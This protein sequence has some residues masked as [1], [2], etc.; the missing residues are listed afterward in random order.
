MKKRSSYYNRTSHPQTKNNDNNKKHF[1]QNLCNSHPKNKNLSPSLS[2]LHL[3]RQ[4]NKFSKKP[5]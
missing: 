3:Q 2:P 5:A 1:V 4:K